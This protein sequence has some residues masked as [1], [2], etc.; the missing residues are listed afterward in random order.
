MLQGSKNTTSPQ[1]LLFKKLFSLILVVVVD[2][3]QVHVDKQWVEDLGEFSSVAVQDRLNKLLQAVI[4][5]WVEDRVPLLA[6]GRQDNVDVW[7]VFPT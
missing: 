3:L 7:L 4:V 5:E 1:H 6:I 2:Q